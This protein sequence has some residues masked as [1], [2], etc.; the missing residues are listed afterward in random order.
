MSARRNFFEREARSTNGG[1][2]R[3]VGAW[4]ASG[5]G[6]PGRRRCFQKICKKTMKNL[7]FF[8][9]FKGNFAI[10]SKTLTFIDFFSQVW[11]KV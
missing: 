5:G 2:V 6:A 10:F 3:G 11:T 1:L 8:E 7:Q 4:G 9:N